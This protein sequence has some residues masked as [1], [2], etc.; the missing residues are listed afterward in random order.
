MSPTLYEHCQRPDAPAGS[1]NIVGDARP[2]AQGPAI[3]TPYSRRTH[4]K[5][6]PPPSLHLAQK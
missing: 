2:K 3:P 4:P 1:L 6:D 5:T